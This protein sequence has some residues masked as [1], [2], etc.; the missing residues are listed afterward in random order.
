[1]GSRNEFR[2][3]SKADVTSH[4][5]ATEICSEIPLKHEVFFASSLALRSEKV[6]LRS[7]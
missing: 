5:K 6:R 7:G 4:Q 3:L 1:M 2:W